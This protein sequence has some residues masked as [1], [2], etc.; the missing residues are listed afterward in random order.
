VL[1]YYMPVS[2]YYRLAKMIEA[3]PLFD[4]KRARGKLRRYVES[5]DTA[6]RNKAEIMVDHFLDDV[7]PLREMKGEARSMV[8]TGGIERAVQYFGAFR[9]VLAERRSPFLP[10][11]AFSGE[12]NFGEPG[13]R[14]LPQW[15]PQQRDHQPHPGRSLPLPDL[16]R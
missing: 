13:E 8:V 7:L 11:V 4:S 14:S 9:T 16:R 1:E 12:H 5:H 10:I 3:D 2:S 6:I 15:L